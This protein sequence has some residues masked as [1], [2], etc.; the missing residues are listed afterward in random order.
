[1]SN[2]NKCCEKFKTAIGGQALIEG[3]MMRGPE[4]DAIVTRNADGIHV[5][6]SMRK[7]PPKGSVRN[8]PLIRGVRGFF[9]AQVTGVKALMRSVDLSPDQTQEK[10]SKM[11]MWLEKKLG[12][13][14]FQSLVI[15]FA[16]A[17][18]LGLSI[19]LFFLLPM[20]ASGILSNWIE[21]NL[22]LNLI[23]GAVRIII[24]VTYIFL[25]SLLS[26]MKRVFSYHGAEHKTI[27]CYEA[28]LPLT[29]E[30]VRQQSRMH[31]RCGT[32]FLL[33]VMILSILV[34][35]IATSALLTIIPNLEALC[36]GFWFQVIKIGFKL[37]LLP[38]VVAISYEINRLVGRHDNVFTRIL[39]APGMWFQRFTTNEPDD[40]MMEVGIASLQA[41]LPEE[42]G[43]DRW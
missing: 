3:I 25:V 16:V 18:G 23:E 11:D 29:V 6:T 42:E 26:D 17:A 39:T 30:N 7:I 43:A 40:S 33:V 15:G 9:D 32:S 14:K 4:K 37:L 34:F 20:V 22:L 24:F 12:D 41:V 1:M 8:W 35:S 28:G 5:E 27:R 21:S 38:L 36:G 2:R 31:P 10:P 13:K 19:L